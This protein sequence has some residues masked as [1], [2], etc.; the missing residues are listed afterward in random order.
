MP[1]FRT[2]ALVLASA[3][4]LFGIA[5][6]GRGAVPADRAPVALVRPDG[7]VYL[8]WRLLPEDTPDTGFH[9]YRVAGSR[10]A[11]RLTPTPLRATT[12]FV[13]TTADLTLT[14]RWLIRAVRRGRE[15]R[16]GETEIRLDPASP[17]LAY[18]RIPLRGH[19][20]FS[21]VAIA[22]LDG[23]GRL[24]FV[25]KQPE[26]VSDP[27]VWRPAET[28]FKIEAYR[29]DGTFLWQRDLGWNIEQGVWWSPMIAADLDG[30]GRAEI[31]LKTAPHAPIYRNA[32]GRI[33]DGPEYLSVWD[34]QTGRELARV[35]W[36][37]RGNI[38]DWGDPVG[39][40]ASRHLIGIAN[41]DGRRPSL[42]ALRGTYTTMLV[43]VWD[44]RD[45]RLV[46]RWSWN[47][48]HDTPPT[49]GQ[50][51]HGMHAADVDGDGREE[52][53]LGAALL[54][55]DG[56]L[57]WN[58]GMGHPDIV[59]VTD[60]LPQRPGLEIAYGFETAQRS[61]GFCVVAAESGKIL[62]GCA[63]TNSHIHSQGLLADIDPTNP[64][65]E[66]YGGEKFL[67][68]RWLYGAANGQLLSQEDFGT[69]AP[70]AVYWD[71][72]HV[73]PFVHREG[74]LA[75]YR[76]PELDR[77]EGRIIAVADL[78][79]DWREELIV[80]VPG[81]LRIYTTRIP[82]ACRHVWLMSDPLYRSGVAHAAMGYLFPPQLR[83]PLT[84]ETG[85]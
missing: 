21:K 45:G 58:L 77:I 56:R 16:N 18:V 4:L 70:I 50:G 25:L 53:L 43:D 1:R 63:H 72:T 15:Q 35:D 13:D 31:A 59:Y 52:I 27:G 83:R 48:D 60:I 75:K 12:D 34:G 73:K 5:Q 79:G 24:D 84:A 44:F 3:L 68:N 30:D 10:P 54:N 6:P 40:R 32:A 47:G 78:L 67:T 14:N 80:S 62:W 39:N 38:A 74:R 2:I 22:D 76:G 61:N 9:V 11:L 85:H 20:R 66:L 64:G 65:L 19:H 28:T 71:E 8:G 42:L 41:L 82:A 36:P 46:K 33:L 57:R 81:E 29:H 49:R 17:A 55:P 51:M 7:S 23:D 37:L 26:Q 69:L